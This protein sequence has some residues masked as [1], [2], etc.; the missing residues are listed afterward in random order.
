MDVHRTYLFI[1]RYYIKNK[2]FPAQAIRT[3]H[4]NAYCIYISTFEHLSMF[5]GDAGLIICHHEQPKW[6]NEKSETK[7]IK[8][9]YIHLKLHGVAKLATSWKRVSFSLASQAHPSLSCSKSERK[10]EYLLFLICRCRLFSASTSTNN[11][12]DRKF[13]PSF[14]FIYVFFDINL[15]MWCLDLWPFPLEFPNVSPL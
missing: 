14:N 2:K 7:L 5:L 12:E 4:F 1:T 3:R 13:L 15:R 9:H 6:I 8:Y 10:H 11:D